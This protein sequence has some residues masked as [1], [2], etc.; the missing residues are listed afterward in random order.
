M[1]STGASPTS[2]SEVER[3]GLTQA[4]SSERERIIVDNQAAAA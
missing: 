4:L 3:T 1:T 2:Q